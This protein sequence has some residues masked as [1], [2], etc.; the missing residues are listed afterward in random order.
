MICLVKR[1][2]MGFAKTGIVVISFI[3]LASCSGRSQPAPVMSL[4]TAVAK[5]NNLTEIDGDTYK[6]QKGDTLFAVA[7]YSGNDYQD[8]AKYNSIQAPYNIYPGQNLSLISSSEKNKN[9][10]ISSKPN[11]YPKVVVDPAKTQAYG[12]RRNN[13]HREKSKKSDQTSDK[14]DNNV[15]WIWPASGKSTSAVVGSDGTNRGV[16]IKGDLYSPISAAASG[17]VVYAGN[18]LKGYGNLVII[19]HE[20]N[21]LSAYAHNDTILVG[22]QRYVKQGQK[23]ATMGRTGSKDVMLHFEI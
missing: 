2:L 1:K 6:V 4:N 22:E 11:S 20:N 23:I 9:N 21:L 8:L 12:K 3:L 18:A 14:L 19:K 10:D 13:K 15:V 7:F 17:K 16:D 5:Q